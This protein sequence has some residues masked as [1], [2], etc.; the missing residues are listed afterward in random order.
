LARSAIV[1]VGNGPLTAWTSPVLPV[2]FVV[3]LDTVLDLGPLISS[4]IA[5]VC[6]WRRP[7]C[8]RP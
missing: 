8:S 7:R 3:E 1:P 5:V 4:H 6:C 2:L